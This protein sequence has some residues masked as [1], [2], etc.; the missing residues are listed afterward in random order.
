MNAEKIY[1]VTLMFYKLA[2]LNYTS[3]TK[4]NVEYRDRFHG[5]EGDERKQLIEAEAKAKGF[6]IVP[7]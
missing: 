1:N 6:T 5:T 3:T 7:D 2:A 4:N